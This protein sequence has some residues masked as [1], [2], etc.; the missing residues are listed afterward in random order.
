MLRPPKAPVCALVS[1][2]LDSVVLLYR[3]SAAGARVLPLY[4]RCGLVWEAAELAWLR[5]ALRQAPGRRWPLR[6]VKM[7]IRGLYGP[8]WSLTGPGIPT[9]RSPHTADYLPGRNPFLLSLAAVIAVRHGITTLAMGTLKSNP[10]GD[11]KPR[12]FRQMARALSLAFRRRIRIR[13]PLIGLTKPQLIRASARLPLGMTFSCMQPQG[14]RPCG[15]CLK[16]YERQ[17]AFRAA[18]VADPTDYAA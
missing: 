2:G 15:S 7:P 18:H 16:C 14:T 4:I 6:V 11:A 13:T 10:Y 9:A 8:H 3:L 17:Q 5:R 1:G 12:F